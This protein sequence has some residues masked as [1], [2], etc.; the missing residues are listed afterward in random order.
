M[1]I[2][3]LYTKMEQETLFSPYSLAEP[4]IV[5]TSPEKALGKGQAR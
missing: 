2:T 4:Y 3:R 1:L 5:Q